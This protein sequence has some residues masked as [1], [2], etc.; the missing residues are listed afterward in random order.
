MVFMEIS[1]EAAGKKLGQKNVFLL[2]VR[3]PEEFA[4]SKIKDFI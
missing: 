1:V 3:L 2:D 4:V